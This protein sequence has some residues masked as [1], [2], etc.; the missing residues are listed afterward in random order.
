MDEIATVIL[1]VGSLGRGIGGQQNANSVL[2]GSSLKCLVDSD[3]V[4]VWHTSDNRE[5]SGA[6]TCV[7]KH[8]F[9]V[10]E[11]VSVLREHDYAL[12]V[13]CAARLQVPLYPAK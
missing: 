9:E 13:P 5:D 3:P 1:E 7:L 2:A 6:V 12:G 4:L 10:L 11:G 8:L